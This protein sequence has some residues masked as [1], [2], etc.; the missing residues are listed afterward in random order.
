MLVP[1]RTRTLFTQRSSFRPAR[2]LPSTSLPVR[3]TVSILDT[4]RRLI[5]SRCS[6][7]TILRLALPD[8]I[9]TRRLL[10]QRR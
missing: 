2:A 10:T 9:R 8:G 7:V 5:L 4:A 6:R 3:T 1:W